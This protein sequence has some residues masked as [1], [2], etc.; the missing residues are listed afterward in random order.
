MACPATTQIAAGLAA[1]D[2]VV[3]RIAGHRLCRL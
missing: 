3:D 2:A 1:A